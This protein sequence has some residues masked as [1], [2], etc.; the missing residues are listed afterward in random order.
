MTFFVKKC[1]KAKYQL[2]TEITSINPRNR[3]RA[4]RPGGFN[5]AANG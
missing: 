1:T 2:L 3:P 4:V 5:A